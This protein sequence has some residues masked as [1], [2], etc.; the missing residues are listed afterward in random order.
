MVILLNPMFLLFISILSGILLGKIKIYEFKLGASGVLISSLFIS[1]VDLEMLRNTLNVQNYIL[2]PKSLF[3]FSLILF[4]APVGLLAGKRLIS[5]MR[6]YGLKFLIL[7]LT[8]TFSGFVSANLLSY[9]F[10]LKDKSIISGLFAGALTSSPGLAAA[11]ENAKDSVS[12]SM[13]GLG[14]AFAYVP[15]VLVVILSIHIL[16]IIF[17]IDLEKE[18]KSLKS[19]D[20]KKDKKV[21]FDF[22]AF[23]LVVLVGILIG[24]IKIELFGTHLSLGITGGVLISSLTFGSVKRIKNLRFDMED[25]DLNLIK[26]MGLLLFLSSVGLRYGYKSISSIDFQGLVY[27]LISFSAGFLAILT[28]FLV[29]KYVF[30]INWIILSGAICGGM[31]STPGLGVAI[32]SS[33]SNDP[34]HGYGAT[35]PFALIFMVIFIIMNLR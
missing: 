1:W 15:G 2:I 24:Y 33:K 28:G 31:T 3:L 30:K 27:M 18:R 20:D 29:G 7:A 4:I 14:Y 6:E 26:E 9:I 32:D 13:I 8:I 34:V 23:S 25:E 10:K 17:K 5:V 19:Y 12:S 21:R 35:Y 11:L 16:P 22:V